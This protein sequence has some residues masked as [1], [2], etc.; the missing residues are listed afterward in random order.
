MFRNE[1]KA[2]ELFLFNS[3]L[4]QQ[5]LRFLITV[6][7]TESWLENSFYLSCVYINVHT[8]ECRI[9]ACSRHE[10]NITRHWHDKSCASEGQYILN[11]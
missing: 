1:K 7:I 5:L 8:P 6:I 2:V 10:F 4:Q 9:R 11:A 3:L